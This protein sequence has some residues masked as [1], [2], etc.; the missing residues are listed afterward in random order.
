MYVHVYVRMTFNIQNRV[1]LN[2]D[3]IFHKMTETITAQCISNVLLTLNE[4]SY[5]N[6]KTLLGVITLTDVL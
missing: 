2:M 3:K 4:A 5:L 6:T 1:L